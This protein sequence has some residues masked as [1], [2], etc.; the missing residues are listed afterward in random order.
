MDNNVLIN[1]LKNK[2]LDK[3][4]P[5]VNVKYNNLLESRDKRD[6]QHTTTIWKPIIGSIEKHDIKP[7]DLHIKI[8]KPDISTIKDAFE[9][10]LTSRN[11]QKNT[12]ENKLNSKL[13]LDDIKIDENLLKLDNDFDNLKKLANNNLSID[14]SKSIDLSIDELLYSIKNIN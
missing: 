7:V 9:K 4:N 1:K 5:D 6:F 8:T 11:I 3:Y 12:I 14:Q 13:K 10:E 2:N